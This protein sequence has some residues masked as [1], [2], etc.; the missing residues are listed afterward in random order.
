MRGLA[1]VAV[2]MV[3][4][5][6]AYQTASDLGYFLG[7]APTSKNCR[8]LAGSASFS[9]SED[10]ALWSKGEAVVTAGGL[11]SAFYE[12]GTEEGALY[13]VTLADET[14]TFVQSLQYIGLVPTYDVE[15]R[16]RR[17]ALEDWPSDKKFRPHGIHVRKPRIFVVNHGVE[18]GS[19]LEVFE[20]V[21]LSLIHISEPTRPY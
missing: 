6:G 9:S 16:A 20:G 1:S 11:R 3:M 8:Q 21:D 13:A 19:S 17:L 14:S 12:G 4:V 15:P 10:A 7:E 2:L 5:A 18:K